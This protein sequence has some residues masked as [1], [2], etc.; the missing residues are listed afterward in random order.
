VAPDA[1]LEGGPLRRVQVSERLG[2]QQQ[3]AELAPAVWVRH[4]GV[5]QQ[6]PG[7][8]FGRQSEAARSSRVPPESAPESV[9]HRPTVT[10]L[11]VHLDRHL[12]GARPTRQMNPVQHRV[13]KVPMCA[14]KPAAVEL[15][16]H[17]L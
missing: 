14:S 10:Q 5:P 6:M 16:Y 1:F 4:N 7:L 9:V 8:P 11:K 13:V 3:I 17:R 12:A 15:P 2:E